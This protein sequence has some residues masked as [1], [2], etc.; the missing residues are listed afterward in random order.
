MAKRRVRGQTASLTPDHKKSR[1]DSIYVAIG[2]VSH[3][4]GKLW[5]RATTLLETAPQSKVCS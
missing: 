2:G 3:I 4:V 5:T 1:I